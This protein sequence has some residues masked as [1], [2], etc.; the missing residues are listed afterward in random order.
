MR[1]ACLQFTIG[2]FILLATD[3][4]ADSIFFCNPML[5]H[6]FK[7][8]GGAKKGKCLVPGE[9]GHPPRI[10]WDT[11][12][13]DQIF[14]G[15]SANQTELQELGGRGFLS[16][17]RLASYSNPVRVDEIENAYYLAH[18]YC[19]YDANLGL[20]SKKYR[21]VLNVRINEVRPNQ[22]NITEIRCGTIDALKKLSD[23]QLA[24]HDRAERRYVEEES[25]RVQ[26]V[27]LPKS[28]EELTA[29]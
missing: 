4:S 23:S 24:L 16:H 27:G 8:D 20:Q 26:M 22:F 25:R 18:S 13:L 6:V 17:I 2:F 1:A 5:G 28:F 9:S 10:I 15:V 12:P 14:I 21:V 3:V 29:H 7:G 19:T 11:I